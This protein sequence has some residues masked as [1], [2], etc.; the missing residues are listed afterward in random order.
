METFIKW[1]LTIPGASTILIVLLLV[2][3][4]VVILILVLAVIQGREIVL[5]PF[6]IGEVVKRPKPLSQPIAVPS[7]N[8]VN[9]FK[10]D[11]HIVI[12]RSVVKEGGKRFVRDT[13]SMVASLI[14]PKIG[15]QITYEDPHFSIARPASHLIVIGSPRY[16]PLPETIQRYFD[17][18]CEYIFSSP[19]DFSTSRILKIVTRYGDELTSSTDRRIE[20]SEIEVDYGILFCGN[21]SNNKRVLWMSGIHGQGTVGVYQY[22]A[23]NASQIQAL[24]DQKENS[25]ICWLLRIKYDKSESDYLKAIREIE[26]LGNPHPCQKKE[27]DR[28]PTALVCD[29]GNVILYFDRT[30]TY[31]AIAHYLDATYSEI[32]K[33]IEKTDL[34]QRYENGQLDDQEFLERLS[35]IIGDPDHRIDGKLLREFW[36]DIFWP[37]YEM[38]EA[39]RNL[40]K[41]G[42]KLILL[43][44]TNS[45]HF[46]NVKRDYPE[47]IGLFDKMV[48]SYEAKVSKPDPAI[49]STAINLVLT[50][51]CPESTLSDVLYIDDDE[52][53]IRVARSL[54]LDGYVFRSYPHFI[55]WLRKKGIYVP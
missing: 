50:Q 48:L 54:N 15:D 55:F 6:K 16:N 31:R 28:K 39:L 49:F 8:Y 43:S 14:A 46:E 20:E 4:I 27:F 9:L 45:L 5:G 32:Q 30:R 19:G 42:I 12:S 10:L 17:L 35:L 24:L 23:Q 36:A 52:E 40:K 22:L 37:N 18:P 47:I 3:A 26:V 29:L 34:R 53:Y 1:F 33:K 7:P 38:F 11:G 13:D 51:C 25:G 21:L 41:A 44:N 2:I